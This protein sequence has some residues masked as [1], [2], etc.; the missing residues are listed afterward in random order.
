M[1][2]RGAV[3]LNEISESDD[4]SSEVNFNEGTF[5]LGL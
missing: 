2:N 3:V 5:L 1:A 4:G